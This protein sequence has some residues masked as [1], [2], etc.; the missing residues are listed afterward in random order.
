[1]NKY[2]YTLCSANHLSYAKTMIDSFSKYHQDYKII[3]GLV[4]KID[5]RFQT[6][7]F[8][9]CTIIEVHNLSIDGFEEMSTSYSILEL[10]CSLKPFF[11]KY[12]FDKYSA[13][14]LFYIDTDIFF[15][16]SLNIVEENFLE[17]DILLTPHFFTPLPIDEL[18]PLERNILI[19]GIY[20]A[21]FIG[22]KK[23]KNVV[24]FIDWWCSHLKKE[25][26]YDF[27]NGMGVDQVW[28]NNVP[29]FFIKVGVLSNMGLNV[30]YWNLHE[31]TIDYKND[32]YFINKTLPLI[33]YHASGFDLNNPQNISKHQNRFNFDNYPQLKELLINYSSSVIK[34][35]HDFFSTLSCIYIKKRKKSFGI[36]KFIN[37]AI[38]F[39]GFKIVKI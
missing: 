33:F 14:F 35:N 26:Y 22:M 15:Y 27:A 6:D 29:L 34:N 1:M 23:T 32:T 28:L 5:N 25:C 39:L 37:I 7:F 12:I 13:D 11:A 38:S 36:I 8:N 10:N 9:N 19:S 24:E 30:A 4:D 3:I 2:L 16:S 31:R 18:L 20:N 17:N 21:G